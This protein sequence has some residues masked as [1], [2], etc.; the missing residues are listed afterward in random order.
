MAKGFS[1][2]VDVGYSETTSPMPTAVHVKMIP[3]DVCQAF[4]QAYLKEYV[5]MSLPLGSDELF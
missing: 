1:Q 4:V 3:L 5:V 2:V